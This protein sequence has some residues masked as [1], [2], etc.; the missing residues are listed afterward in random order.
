MLKK[1]IIAIW[2]VVVMMLS[3][4][5]N[6]VPMTVLATEK[7][8]LKLVEEAFRS[9]KMTAGEKMHMS[10]KLRLK[11]S[12]CV[13]P[14][15][16]ITPENN[17]NISF[18]NIEVKNTEDVQSSTLLY[19]SK[20][21][22]IQLDYDIYVDDFAT[23]GEY[24]YAISYEPKS[25]STMED[26][27][28]PI[29]PSG[30]LIMKV[31]VAGEK[32]PPQISIVSDSEFHCNAGETVNMTFTLKNEGE[33]KALNT[34]VFA[35]Y[36]LFSDI[37]IPNY[38]P[39]NQ[40]VGDLKA[41]TSKK[42]TISYKVSEDAETQLI[43]IPLD[44]SAKKENGESVS[45]DTTNYLYLYIEGK[46]PAVEEKTLV[47]LNGVTQ[48]IESPKAGE[49]LMVSF[50]LENSGNTEVENIKI[51]PVNISS[52]GF[53]PVSSEPYQYI[54]KIGIGE[55]K[56]V[57]FVLKVGKE[58]N[59]GLNIFEINYSYEVKGMEYPSN[60][61]SLYI[62][63]VQKETTVLD[64]EEKILLL[65]NNVKQSV[66]S[67]KAGQQ[68]TISFYLE[69]AGDVDVEN[70]KVLPTSL[71][72][73]GFEPVNSEP[74]QYI[75]KIGVGEKK[76]VSLKLK[77]GKDI[78]AGLN[79]LGINY[80]YEVKGIKQ[81]SEDVTLYVFDVQNS[82]EAVEISRPKLMVSNFYTDVEDVKAGS[83]FDFT[84]DILNTNDSIS[85]KNI[86]VTVTG[87]SNA[88]SVTAGG[89]SFFVNEIK[90]QQTAP[91]T[92]NL[93]ASAAATTGAYPINIKIEY[94]YEGMVATSSYSGEVVEE[95]ILLQVK[96]NLRPSVEN[97]Y[98]GSWD[99]PM[100][101]QPTMLSFEFYNMGKSTL[102]NT[103]I[104]IEGDFTLSN[105]SNSYYIG[106]IAAG[107]PEYI[108]FEVV[109]MVEGNAVGKMII[110][111]EDSNG[112]E[113]TMEK[114]FTTYVMGEMSWED[115]GYID[116]GYMD[117]G[118]ED[119]SMQTGGEVAKES[120]VPL[121]MFLA[122]Q[123]GIMVIVIPVTRVIYLSIYKRKM[124]KEDAE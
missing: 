17:T 35:D 19:V 93:K 103:Y 87:A 79:T 72:S 25:S 113:V 46:S 91:I 77:V 112:D 51:S 57:S 98:I 118:F 80:S 26:E 123:A 58:V 34:Y 39:L 71:S 120:I 92:I 84:F 63:N 44:I 43:K 65:L 122:I 95:E 18:K 86:K 97:V 1:K 7:T 15:F 13:N 40:K 29:V 38:T 110:H 24:E 88:F 109:P 81:P 16:T 2:M 9:V 45:N 101:N 104:T 56:Q 12:Y 68:I 78:K 74:Y 121:W 124:K 105:G 111:M 6:T 62:L 106:N 89:N 100:L 67:P 5:Y 14:V 11:E 32:E 115:P 23:I 117:P 94:E 55:K 116:P 119:P 47:L 30:K 83:V 37:L 28:E 60:P 73:S 61:E 31:V 114:E 76:Q 42:V 4:V 69:N 54:E 33:L 85:A 10:I 96:E 50:Y 75:E 21:C 20:D 108:E 53:E 66:A 8:N 36:T 82:E 59:E 27:E 70:I 49:E 3:I 52:S 102:N 41:N 90:P 48:S 64:P 99:T 22:A 107:M